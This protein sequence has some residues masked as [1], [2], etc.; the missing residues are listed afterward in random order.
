[1]E[2]LLEHSDVGLMGRLR[3]LPCDDLVE[4]EIT[5]PEGEIR[6]AELRKTETFWDRQ[7]ALLCSL[8]D[9]THHKR[10]EADPRK[11]VLIDRLTGLP[12]RAQLLKR[13]KMAMGRASSRP[14]FLFAL[15]RIDLDDFHRI[16]EDFGREA[17]DR[18]LA[19]VSQ[20]VH[21]CLGAFDT[22]ARFGGDEFVV[23]A[24]GLRSPSEG[25]QLVQKIRSK[26]ADPI[27]LEGQRITPWASIGV[28]LSNKPYEGPSEMLREAKKA[29][30]EAKDSG[31]G[32]F[33]FGDHKTYKEAVLALQAEDASG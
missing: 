15:L 29:L 31:P 17:G 2:T 20:I 13:L 26:L 3:A 1:M 32:G 30:Q 16:N 4:M 28:A 25:L 22:A 8:R 10:A 24:G 14:E 11:Y 7:E 12:N 27:E 23:L 5:G 18:M 21:G 9:I 33:R 6:I 19:M